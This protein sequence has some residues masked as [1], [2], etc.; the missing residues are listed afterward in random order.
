MNYVNAKLKLCLKLKIIFMVRSNHLGNGVDGQALT[1]NWVLP[2]F[3]SAE[4]KRCV[5]RI[6][7]NVFCIITVFLLIFFLLYVCMLT[8]LPFHIEDKDDKILGF[9]LFVC[10]FSFIV[11]LK[12]MF[13]LVSKYLFKVS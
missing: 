10:L 4:T 8:F 5:F 3:P 2:Y 11:S 13:M 1:Y 12:I 6:R 9:F 7:Y